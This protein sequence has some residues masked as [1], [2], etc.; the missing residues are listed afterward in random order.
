M[1]SSA[2]RTLTPS[3][4]RLRLPSPSTTGRRWRPTC[5]R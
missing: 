5:Q 4:P 1:A 3:W 2:R